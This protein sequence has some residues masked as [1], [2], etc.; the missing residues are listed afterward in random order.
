MRGCKNS[1]IHKAV[2]ILWIRTAL[3]MI[4]TNSEGNRQGSPNLELIIKNYQQRR[5]RRTATLME[6]RG[7][8]QPPVCRPHKRTGSSVL[9]CPLP[10]PMRQISLC[11]GRAP[12]G[13]AKRHSQRLWRRA[14][15]PESQR[16]ARAGRRHDGAVYP[17]RT[18]NEPS[19]HQSGF[20]KDE[21][22]GTYDWILDEF[23]CP[24][25]RLRA[26]LDLPENYEQIKTL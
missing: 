6:E 14:R 3:C 21:S 16:R 26:R 18:V 9:R 24:P 15:W 25:L 7:G 8:C 13:S 5:Q 19:S 11:P 4:S 2:F 23:A 17:E 12:L 1:I 20:H 10:I 22:E